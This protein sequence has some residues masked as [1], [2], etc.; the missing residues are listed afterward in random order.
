MPTWRDA[1]WTVPLLP[2]ISWLW[3]AVA[4]FFC[5]PGVRAGPTL[6]LLLAGDADPELSSQIRSEARE[7]GLDTETVGDTLGRSDD[8]LLALHGAVAIVHVVSPEHV[9]VSVAASGERVPYAA[10]LE[11]HGARA[12]TFAVSIVELIRARLVELERR[13]PTPEATAR[14]PA[15]PPSAPPAASAPSPN[16][17]PAPTHERLPTRAPPPRSDAHEPMLWLSTGGAGLLA[18]GGLGASGGVSLGFGVE[19]SERLWASAFALL[20]LL[21]NVARG[22]EGSADILVYG[23]AAKLGYRFAALG[24]GWFLEAGPGAGLV[25]LD[26]DADA[27]APGVGHKDTLRAGIFF[28]HAG[29]SGNVTPWLALRA[30]VAGGTSAPRPVLR[31]AGRD[32]ATFGHALTL[33]TLDAEFGW[34]LGKG[35]GTP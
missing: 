15:L 16:M 27:V 29:L 32:V 9:T 19:P 10:D 22:P 17:P 5:A 25:V 13:Q 23:Y 2:R 33:A 12:E 34:P 26:V 24:D 14:A 1:C 8:A 7:L 30:S 18:R 4:L 20:P 21:E 6:R 35:A 28:V 3:A 11:R 31:F